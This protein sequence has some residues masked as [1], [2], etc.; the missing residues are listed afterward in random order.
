MKISCVQMD[1]KLALSQADLAFNF[2]HAEEMVRKTIEQEKPDV[3]VLPETWNIGFFPKENL[4]EMCDADGKRTKALMSGL[5][6]EYKTNIVAGSVG[7]LREGKCY[8]TA[9]VFDREGNCVYTYDKMH[10]FSP[11]GEHEAF[12][13][14]RE[15]GTFQLDGVNCGLIICYDIRFCELVRSIALKGVDVMFV[16]AQWPAL[17]T[18]HIDTLTLARAIENQMF[19]AFTN[20]VAT[21]YGC[22]CGG[23]SALIDPWG[24][25]LAHAGDQEEIISADFD[26]S[27]VQGIRESINVFRDRK[28]ELYKVH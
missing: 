14:G 28:P 22:T 12:E 4:S 19:L 6:R 8:N 17:R 18:A 2:A 3:V 13:Y 23:S 10:C 5:A 26:L 1:M 15:Y 27:I 20:S 11:S 16:V 9:Y 24:V 7:T 25:R 21:A